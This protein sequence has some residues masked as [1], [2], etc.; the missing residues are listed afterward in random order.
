[1]ADER[2][3]VLPASPLQFQDKFA[4]LRILH[5]IEVVGQFLADQGLAFDGFRKVPGLCLSERQSAVTPF[6][7]SKVGFLGKLC[8]IPCLG[9]TS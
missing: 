9:F 3:H 5:L 7:A 6:P 8:G 4:Q 1:V 2:I